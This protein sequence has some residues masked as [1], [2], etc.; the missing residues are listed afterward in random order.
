MRA[1]FEVTKLI[2]KFLP[3]STKSALPS[4][5]ALVALYLR[6]TLAWHLVGKQFLIIGKKTRRMSSA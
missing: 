2:P 1:G 6:V 3:Y 4:H 5:P